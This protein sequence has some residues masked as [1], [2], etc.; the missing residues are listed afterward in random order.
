[1]EKE[2]NLKYEGHAVSPQTKKF[3]LESE[4]SG[5]GTYKIEAYWINRETKEKEDYLRIGY[6]PETKEIEYIDFDGGPWLTYGSTVKNKYVVTGFT[7]DGNF[8]N[9][10][11]LLTECVSVG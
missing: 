7:H 4:T 3:I 11:I 5:V 1:M 9:V 6:K 10:K 2:I 8:N